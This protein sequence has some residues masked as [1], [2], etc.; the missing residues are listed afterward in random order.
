MRSGADFCD[1]SQMTKG[2]LTTLAVML[3]CTIVPVAQL[4]LAPFGP[5]LGA[6]FGIR[7]VDTKGERPLVA[8]AKFGGVVAL[9]SAA[10]L[11]AIAVTL[12]S[13][14]AMPGQ[15]I[16]LTWLAVAVFAGY[17]AVMSTLGG[18]Y[19]LLKMRMAAGE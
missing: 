19:R 11:A 3:A 7:W 10:I 9:A 16:I 13:A 12:V 6:Y 18:L 4:L 8:A 2:L 5:F 17:V 14:V 15:F 1:N